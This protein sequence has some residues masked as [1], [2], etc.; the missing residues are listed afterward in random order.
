MGYEIVTGSVFMIYPD[1]K[2]FALKCDQTKAMELVHL[3]DG[4]TVIEE[5]N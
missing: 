2:S 4:Y 3:G 1:G 5:R